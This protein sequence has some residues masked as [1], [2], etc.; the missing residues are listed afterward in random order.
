M[1]S[2]PEKPKKA[3]T[4][5]PKK[6]KKAKKAKEKK[7]EKVNS[8]LKLSSIIGMESPSFSPLKTL[9]SNTNMAQN[10]SAISPFTFT[11]TN[12]NPFRDNPTNQKK[13]IQIPV[14][15]NEELQKKQERLNLYESFL[16]NSDCDYF[17]FWFSRSLS[18]SDQVQKVFRK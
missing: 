5:K 10:T 12:L 2:K 17:F 1:A 6:E 13:E 9:Q 11:K 7:R 8:S 14:M 15:T 16:M 3:K 4:K 18:L